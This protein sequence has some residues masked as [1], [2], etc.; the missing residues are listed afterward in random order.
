MTL[1]WIMK[2]KIALLIGEQNARKTILQSSERQ[3]SNESI[4]LF[5]SIS[6]FRS[7]VRVLNI[8]H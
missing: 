2:I 5:E 4:R 3:N 7:S 8:E 6:S 1:R